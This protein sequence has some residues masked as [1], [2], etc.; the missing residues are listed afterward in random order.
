MG[1]TMIRSMSCLA[2]PDL[3]LPSQGRSCGGG[4]RC[5]LCAKCWLASYLRLGEFYFLA[6]RP[7][8]LVF[9]PVLLA[10]L[11]SRGASC[12]A[13]NSVHLPINSWSGVTKQ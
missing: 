9:S 1:E 7:F 4:R 3:A 6:G 8:S 5:P 2:E 11:V 12:A 10:T 13:V